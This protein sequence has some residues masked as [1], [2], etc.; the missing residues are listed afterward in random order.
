MKISITIEGDGD[1]LSGL[2][3]EVLKDR[4]DVE[5][6]TEKLTQ[7]EI[8]IRGSK[9]PDNSPDDHRF[10]VIFENIGWP[11]YHLY[12]IILQYHSSEDPTCFCMTA[13]ELE[14]YQL[15]DSGLTLKRE[16]LSRII[17]GARQTTNKFELPPIM[18]IKSFGLN[19]K[20]CINKEMIPVFNRYKQIQLSAYRDELQQRDFYFPGEE[21]GS[22]SEPP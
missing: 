3:S 13:E 17:G 4:M 15:N 20:F 19:K 21:P 12:D 5:K 8:V 16:Q 7:S 10:N 22:L 1:A 11:A 2:I 18:E 9:A 14:K 6:L